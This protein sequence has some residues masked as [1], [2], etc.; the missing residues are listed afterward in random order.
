MND[1]FLERLRAAATAGWLTVLIGAIWMTLAWLV[2]LLIGRAEPK[3]LR[4][5]WG[6]EHMEW[7]AI[8]AMMLWFFAAFKLLLFVAVL[9]SIWLSLWYAR[10]TPAA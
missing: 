1:V 10:L 4:R 7:P 8:R 2:W 6:V 9:V 5:M 3:W